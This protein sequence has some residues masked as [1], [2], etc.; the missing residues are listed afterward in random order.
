M[1]PADKLVATV[2]GS[3][4]VSKNEAVS[5]KINSNLPWNKTENK[6]DAFFSGINLQP[7]RVNGLYP[8]RLLVIDV[9]KGNEIV[10]NSSGSFDV[11][12]EV[13]K[14]ASNTGGV[15]YT[16]GGLDTAWAFTLPITPQQLSVTDQFAINTTATM[17]GVVEEHN[18]VKFKMISRRYNRGI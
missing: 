17:R 1:P 9:T 18:G 3:G 10:S 13:V 12:G 14:N 11:D 15:S 8:Y 7:D 2:D 16:I 6:K 5:Q 4:D